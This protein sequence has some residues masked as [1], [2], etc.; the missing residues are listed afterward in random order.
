VYPNDTLASYPGGPFLGSYPGAYAKAAPWFAAT[1]TEEGADK[2]RADSKGRLHDA[3]CSFEAPAKFP[4]CSCGTWPALHLNATPT[5][6]RED[7]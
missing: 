2:Q 3:D 4:V 5:E 6:E 1:P 7:G